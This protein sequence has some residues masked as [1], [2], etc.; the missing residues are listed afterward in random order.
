M[1]RNAA[2][3]TK[4]DSIRSTRTPTAINPPP[5]KSGHSPNLRSGSTMPGLPGFIDA[6]DP[7][8]YAHAR[9]GRSM[10]EPPAAGRYIGKRGASG[11][12]HMDNASSRSAGT[13][14][15]GQSLTKDRRP[16]SYKQNTH[17]GS[18]GSNKLTHQGEGGTTA[19]GSIPGGGKG[20]ARWGKGVRQTGTQGRVS[21]LS[22]GTMES[23][24]G[25]AKVS[26]GFG[27]GPK[28]AGH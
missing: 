6:H 7:K 18:F 17:T 3:F 13:M 20:G 25:R 23:M 8:D 9:G 19:A 14:V 15:K 10:G 12:S 24:K 2:R 21:G 28:P 16:G 27:M 22:G 4:G 11:V 1:A 26:K 5:N